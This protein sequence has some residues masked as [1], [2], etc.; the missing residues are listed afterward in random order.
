MLTITRAGIIGETGPFNDVS[1]PDVTAAYF[2]RYKGQAEHAGRV[3]IAYQAKEFVVVATEYG[4]LY[5][6]HHSTVFVSEI[7]LQRV[8]RLPDR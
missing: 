8:R 3:L 7:Y 6:R 4:V 2:G 1:K 5:L